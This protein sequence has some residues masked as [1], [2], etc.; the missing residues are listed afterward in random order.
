MA[1]FFFTA[2]ILKDGQTHIKQGILQANYPLEA[3]DKLHDQIE[4]WDRVVVAASLREINDDGKLGEEVAT[5]KTTHK[6]EE[7]PKQQ[8]LEDLLKFG[9]EFNEATLYSMK[10]TGV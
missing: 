5:T 2:T 8:D 4:K 6:T 1:G 3:L 10:S 9:T 7:Q